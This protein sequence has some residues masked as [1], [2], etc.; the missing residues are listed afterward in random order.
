MSAIG[1]GPPRSEPARSPAHDCQLCPRLA[2]FRQTNRNTF[3]DW[4][5]DPVAP[6]GDVGAEV[7]IV[8]LAPG[9]RGANRTG[10]PFTGD[11]A[12][13]LLYATLIEFGLASGRYAARADDGLRMIGCRVSNAVKCVPPEN[14]PTP[15]E[16][17]TCN[18]FLKSELAAMNRLMAIL[19]LGH[20]AH[21]AVLLA[22]GRKRASCKFSHG[23]THDLG[24]GLRLFDSYH[25]SRYNTNTNR[26]TP[27]MFHDVVGQL[28][29]WSRQRT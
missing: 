23:A 25:C 1:G 11:Y 3:P 29:K 18:V 15:I 28:A 20:I 12:G 2:T 19:A 10:R 26:L 4:H 21:D 13:E 6:F 17:A 7:L 9:L 5:N 8:G 24:N 27:A 22:M 16:V 14:R